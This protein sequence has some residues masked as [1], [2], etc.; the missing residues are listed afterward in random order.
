VRYRSRASPRRVCDPGRRRIQAAYDLFEKIGD[1]AGQA[2][3]ASNLGYAYLSVSGLRDLDQAQ[4]WH[5]RTLDRTPEHNRIGRAAA[6]I[7]LA[8]V[9]YERFRDARARRAPEVELLA[10]L[11]TALA[12]LHRA[13][14]LLPADH[15][16][17]RAT[18]HNQHSSAAWNRP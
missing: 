2:I 15:H 14:D 12:G 3:Q 1:T 4:H 10:H 13:L 16:D 5:Q 9:A 11:N 6:H 8:N 18:A 17:Y 7:S